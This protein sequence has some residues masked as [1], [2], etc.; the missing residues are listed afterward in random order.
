MGFSKGFG[1]SASELPAW[2]VLHEVLLK[3]CWDL[4]L[5]CVYQHMGDRDGFSD[6]SQGNMEKIG[7]IDSLGRSYDP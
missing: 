2:R 1:V 4:T 6:E 3:V 5:A 7:Q